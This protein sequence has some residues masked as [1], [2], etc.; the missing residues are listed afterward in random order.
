MKYAYDSEKAI[1]IGIIK[2]VTR[3]LQRTN[4]RVILR[5]VYGTESLAELNE[6]KVRCVSAVGK[7]AVDDLEALMGHRVLVIEKP[8]SDSWKTMPESLQ[9]LILTRRSL[10]SRVDYDKLV[11]SQPRITKPII[12]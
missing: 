4:S 5:A 1:L 12:T 3:E 2:N 8:N 7:D 9:S 10:L 6:L 11:N